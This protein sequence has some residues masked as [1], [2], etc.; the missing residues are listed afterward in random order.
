MRT[1]LRF[2]WISPRIL[3]PFLSSDI[4]ECTN[5]SHNCHADATC[6]NT[7]GSF[8]CACN[9]GWNGDAVNCTGM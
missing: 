2:R 5:G 8:S 7:E 3:Q 9:P 1:V 4:N 6:R